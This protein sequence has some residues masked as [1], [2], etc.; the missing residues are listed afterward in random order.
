MDDLAEGSIAL[1]ENPRVAAIL[2]AVCDRTGMGFAAIA[3]VT[4]TTWT[5][6]HVLDR[7]DFGLDAG[8]ELNLKTTICNDIRIHGQTIVFDC[9]SASAYWR[10]HPTPVLYGFESYLSMPITLSDGR[11]FG[12]LC[13]LDPDPRNVD[14]AELLATIRGFADEIAVILETPPVMTVA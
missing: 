14:I 2:R 8:D 10:S 13:A 3:R 6:C 5:A 7:I 9:A 4:D 11:F 12:T 1:T